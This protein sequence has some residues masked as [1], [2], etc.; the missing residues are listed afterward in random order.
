MI[1]IG[2]IIIKIKYTDYTNISL[3][4]KNNSYS[5]DIIKNKKQLLNLII[6]DLKE[7]KI[8]NY[9]D[10]LDVNVEIYVNNK[11]LNLIK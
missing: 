11:T 8:Y 10:L 9:N 2:N 1:F 7:N 6:N 4:H 3:K 5:I